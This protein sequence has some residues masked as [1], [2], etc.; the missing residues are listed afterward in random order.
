MK[1]VYV[2]SSTLFSK[3][4]NSLHVMKMAKGFS[5]LIDE[6]ELIVRDISDNKNCYEYYDVEE[7]FEIVNMKVN[8]FKKTA[9]FIY[10]LK[11]F[12][13]FNKR[14]KDPNIIFFG[15]DILTLSIFTFFSNN[16]SIELHSISNSIIKNWMLK[17]LIKYKRFKKIIV[18]S[19]A[20]KHDVITKYNADENNILV[21][22]DG[23]DLQNIDNHEYIN[24]IGYVGSIN[25]GRGIELIISLARKMKNL[26]F[27]IVGGTKI[28]LME[29]LNVSEF[30]DNLILHGYLSQNEIKK[31]I[32][33]MYIMLAPY[34]RKV[35]NSAK[36]SDT[37]KWMSPIKIFEYMSFSKA[38]IV[39]HIKVL[40]E[41]IEPN[42]N[43]VFANHQDVKDWELKILKLINNSDYHQN[44]KKNAYR[45][46]KEKYTWDNRTNNILKF[47]MK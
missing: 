38:I 27:H 47:I 30:P 32:S 11:N 45:T 29:K 9:P 4:A 6:V 44:I 28:E 36:N 42:K 31:F 2:S 21:A 1:L 34:Q 16:V 26:E 46:L 10:L 8:K 18:I 33:E 39:S 35:G 5:K 25:K 12:G 37:A 22:H 14:F 19:E 24:K 17:T 43:A 20:L 41:I 23:A 13:R 3:S 40:E 7:S 15:R